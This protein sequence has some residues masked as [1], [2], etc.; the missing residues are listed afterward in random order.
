MGGMRK[1]VVLMAISVVACSDSGDD[2][3]SGPN[4]A[5]RGGASGGS[6]AGQ[7]A[8]S[9]GSG[10]AAAAASGS[11]GRSSTIVGMS[12]AGG[13][14]GMGA[15]SG[16]GSAGSGGGSGA[17]AGT[18]GSGGSGTAASA[19]VG[20]AQ[21]Y[22]AP[23]LDKS[24]EEDEDCFAGLHT[25]D[26]CQSQV[27]LG[28]NAAVRA[29]FDAYEAGC[30]VNPCPCPAKPT[31]AEDGSPLAAGVSPVAECR[32]GVCFA[33]PPDAE[34]CDGPMECIDVDQGGMCIEATGP[35]RSGTCRGGAGL[36]FLC[37]CASP[38]TPIATPEGEKPIA[39]LSVG[40]LVYSEEET[41]I[42]V[43]PIIRVSRL[44]VFHHRVMQV[45]LS[46]GRTLAI[47]PGHP[48]ADGRAF[49]TLRPNDMLGDAPID[50]AQ[51]VEYPHAFTHDILPASS[52]GTYFAAGVPI[53]STLF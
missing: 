44:E 50:E 48:T 13:Q 28:F 40:D 9:S 18:G 12:G 38:E 20:G 37:D 45:R 25:S 32:E 19:C 22:Q 46:S 52:T 29:E 34:A 11:G 27:A 24:C 14:G 8:S 23:M 42:V 5:G 10:G 36:C 6:S 3:A 17:A 51:L 7:G 21:S 41:G 53:G 49:G 47:S 2:D 39:S 1:L 33:R 16:G 15:G 30:R 26:C 31:R 35:I 4:G 43:V